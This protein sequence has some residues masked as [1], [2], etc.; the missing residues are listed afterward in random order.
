MIG[1]RNV[2]CWFCSVILAVG[3]FS[4]YYASP[5]NI[6]SITFV[7]RT[8]LLFA[9]PVACVYLPFVLRLSRTGQLFLLATGAAL[10]GPASIGLLGVVL[11]VADIPYAADNGVGPG[12]GAALVF[13][14]LIGTV[15]GM[16]YVITFKILC[17]F[18]RVKSGHSHKVATLPEQ[19]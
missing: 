2:V 8:T 1:L 10:I 14:L 5:H 15:A 9:F 12:F 17:R 19:R 13:A 11:A 7:C 4:G 3:L 6:A 18:T 16:A